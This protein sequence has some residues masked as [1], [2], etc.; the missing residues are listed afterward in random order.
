MESVQLTAHLV[1]SPDAVVARFEGEIDMAVADEF[2]AHLQTALVA[3]STDRARPL[4]IDLQAV[5]FFGSAA[6]NDVMRCHDE[7]ASNG[8]AVGLVATSPVVVRVVQATGLDEFITI[9]PTIDDARRSLGW[10]T[11]ISP[12]IRSRAPREQ[13][14]GTDQF[15]LDA[16]NS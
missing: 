3:A 11:Q 14:L 2:W 12:P 8:V 9:Y 6:L 15:G 13:D 4:I 5:D 1:V 7:G 10:A 16:D